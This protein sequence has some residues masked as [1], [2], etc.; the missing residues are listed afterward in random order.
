MSLLTG[1][2]CAQSEPDITSALAARK[3]KRGIAANGLTQKHSLHATDPSVAARSLFG[4]RCAAL[5]TATPCPENVFD[6]DR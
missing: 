1:K 4:G 6:L 5:G 3:T 2:S